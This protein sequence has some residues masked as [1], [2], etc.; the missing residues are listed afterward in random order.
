MSDRFN[1]KNYNLEDALREIGMA[2][3]I[4]DGMGAK[5][6]KTLWGRIASIKDGRA[7]THAENG[8]ADQAESAVR[9]AREVLATLETLCL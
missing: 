9:S 3:I 8:N 6:G 7:I 5:Q 2:E 1:R 4:L